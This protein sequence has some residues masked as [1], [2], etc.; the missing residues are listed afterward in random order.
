MQLSPKSD[1]NFSGNWVA[2][3]GRM[4]RLGT[5]A[6]RNRDKGGAS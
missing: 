3:L 2:L 4:W 1:N 5:S 6:T